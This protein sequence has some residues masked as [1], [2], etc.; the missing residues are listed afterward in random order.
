LR[1]LYLS[2]LSKPIAD[3]QVY[4]IIPRQRV[5]TIVE[6]GIG[7]GRRAGRMI[8]AASYLAPVRQISYTGIDLFEARTEADGPGLTLKAA[9]RLLATTGARVGLVPGDPFLALAR[10]ANALMG[11]DLLI[12][13]AD[14]D[15][16]A[17]AKA[18]FYVP[19]MLHARSLVYQE[20][21]AGPDAPL[22][23]RLLA[24]DEIA[25]LAAV[26]RSRLAA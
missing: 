14:Q 15:P 26:K 20:V 9:H 19:R 13:S 18:W 23:L 12:V 5:A 24:S 7:P 25:R 22:A 6:L 3:R 4:R 17:M 21:S 1:L 8:E 2:Y 10:M 16:G 11:T